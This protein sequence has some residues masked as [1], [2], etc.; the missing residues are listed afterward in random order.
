MYIGKTDPYIC[1]VSTPNSP[2][3]GDNNQ[4]L[5]LDRLSIF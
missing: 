5:N 3:G 4:Q 2:G 1:L